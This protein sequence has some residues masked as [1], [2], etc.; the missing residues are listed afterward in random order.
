MQHFR[1]MGQPFPFSS[2]HDSTTDPTDPIQRLVDEV[3]AKPYHLIP[4]PNLTKPLVAEWCEIISTAFGKVA[5]KMKEPVYWS[6]LISKFL[7]F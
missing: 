6:R 7:S 1:Q 5:P 4:V 3:V 2:Q